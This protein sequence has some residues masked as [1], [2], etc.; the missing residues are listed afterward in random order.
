MEEFAPRTDPRC[1]RARLPALCGADRPAGFRWRH[2][3]FNGT[4]TIVYR[5][6]DGEG[7]LSTAQVSVI[8]TSA[9][10]VPTV[11]ANPTG[12]QAGADGAAVS[13][14]T[15]NSFTDIDGDPLTYT[16][17]GLPAGLT[18]DPVT[19]VIGGTIDHSASQ[20]G[21][22][23]TY[24]VVVTADDG[25]GGTVTHSF[26]FSVTNPAPAAGD[27]TAGTDEDTPVIIDVLGNDSD[28]DGDPLAVTT[29]TAPN[30]TVTINPDGT[31]TYT[32]NPN[33]NG[34]DTITYSVSDGEG[35][36]DTATVTVTVTPVNDAPVTTP[37]TGTTPE[38]TPVTLTPDVSD[39]EGGPLTITDP[40][41]PNGTVTVN[42]DGTITYV[43]NPDFNGTDTITYTV[44]D[45]DG[46]TSTGTITVTVTPVNDAPAVSATPLPDRADVDGATVSIR[47]AGGF[48]DPDGDALTYTATG[49]PAGLT[50]DPATG[51]IG[52]TIDRS[53][54]QVAGGVYTITVTVA[55]SNG[56][57]AS[58]S[59]VLTVTNPDPVAVND[60]AALPLDGTVT[61]PVLA[62]DSDPDGDP[63]TLVSATA[64]SGTVVIN[65]DGTLTYTA[66]ASFNGTDTITYTIIDG[67][68]GTDTATVTITTYRGTDVN[69][70]L[71]GDPFHNLTPDIGPA[72]VAPAFEPVEFVDQPLIISETVNGFRSLNSVAFLTGP[73][74]LFDAINGFRSLGG[75]GEFGDGALPILQVVD[76]LDQMRD[77]RSDIE[78]LFDPRLDDFVL[79]SLTGFSARQLDTGSD[80]VMIEAVARDQVLYVELRDVGPDEASRVVRFELEMADGSALP[81]WLRFDSRGL[82]IIER[83]IGLQ[84]LHLIVRAIR[85]DGSSVTIPVVIQASS[86]EIQIDGEIERQGSARAATFGESLAQAESAR[87]AESA[88]LVAAFGI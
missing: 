48:T 38:D 56:E 5:V 53:A 75:L 69:A 66:N 65:P 87:D 62:N 46:G 54:S 7:G 13:I 44:T 22:N 20:G 39:A 12:D 43:P 25:N 70:L 9:N 10:D 84:E 71:E 32:P 57:T 85:D 49:L 72:F 40:T 37:A 41:A 14:P 68:G 18:I 64:G 28:P 73:H 80:H 15:A 24:T 50:I 31:I 4:D 33:F 61:I 27:D 52:G 36:T 58:D 82:A 59:F 67:E 86:G 11:T 79:R 1:C 78:R 76:Q 29:A 30:G 17:T 51:V 74:P 77:L 88:R 55:D 8:V 34:T 23:G 35:G 19:G 21:T 81:E 3:D 16:A 26:A 83:P 63:L 2:A 6:S 42:P 60:N 47:A 45:P